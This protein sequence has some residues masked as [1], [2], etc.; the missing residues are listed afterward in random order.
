M[1]IN[2]LSSKKIIP[3]YF[4]PNGLPSEEW[5]KLGLKDWQIKVIKNYES[6]GGK[7][8]KKEDVKKIYGITA[9]EYAVLEPFII[10]PEK[11]KTVYS[12]PEFEKKTES[13]ATLLVD[14]NTAD[15]LELTKLSGIGPAFARR[16]VKYRNALGGFFSK[17]Q[18]KEVYGF[19][20]TKY[21][22]CQANCCISNNSGIKKLNLNTATLDELKK[23][24]YMDYYIAKAIID[25]RI[26]KKGIH[27]VEEL[28][29]ISLIHSDLYNKLNPYVSVN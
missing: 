8:Y 27:S 5:K 6:K 7:F 2:R 3:F 9:A 17:E 10:L 14:I 24:P 11:E 21:A 4:N 20:E 22:Q 28:Q 1:S 25:Y 26:I 18:L 15:T 23:H 13:K 29:N 12:K 16:I 19:D